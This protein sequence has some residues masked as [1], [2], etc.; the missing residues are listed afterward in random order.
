[1]TQIIDKVI[2]YAKQNDATFFKDFIELLKIASI[3]TDSIH[4]AE[5]ISAANWLKQYLEKIGV[6]ESR[7]IETTQNPLVIGEWLR[8]GPDKP[9]ILVYGHYD[10][11]PPD[12]IDQWIS[13]PFVPTVRDNHLFS[14]GASDMKGQLM[15]ALSAIQAF[16]A[17]SELPV[18]LKFIFEGEEEIGSPTIENYLMENKDLL[19]ADFA[20]NLDAGMISM[21][22]P[23]IVYGL[24][25]LAYFE[26]KIKGPSHDLHSGLFGGIVYNPAQALCEIL[27]KM[28]SSNGKIMLPNFYNSVIDIDDEEREELKRLPLSEE[29]YLGQSGTTML[30][31][32]TGYSAVERVGARPTLE[33]HGILTG[34][35]G[36]GPK[37]VIPAEAMA[38]ISM[39]LVPNQTPEEVHG[40]LLEFMQKN[41]PGSV[42][43]EIKK[44][45]SD[46]ACVIERD[47]WA[48]TCFASALEKVWNKAPVYKREGGSIPIVS[49]MRT[50]LGMPSVLSGFGLPDDRIHSP[51]ENMN[52]EMWHRGIETVIWFLGTVADYRVKR[53]NP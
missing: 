13:D 34:Y 12:P 41:A 15:I 40:Q 17:T 50:I 5:I 44:L 43:W 26:I 14:R 38:K 6:T 49:H 39:R 22:Y 46:P 45:A 25:G 1:M 18:N 36:E 11:Q 28:K 24:R 4:H 53:L 33:I 42:T 51:N 30:T 35:T 29:Y 9:T 47:F 21:D 32:E 52:L 10:V 20:L 2:A 37:T 27:S 3:S 19:K 8:A 48:T 23:T 16:A 31:G 7:V